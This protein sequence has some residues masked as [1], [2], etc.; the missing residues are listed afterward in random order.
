MLA[1]LCSLVVLDLSDCNLFEIPNHLISLSSLESLNLSGTMIETIPASLKQVSGMYDLNLSNCKRLQSLPE[2][3]FLIYNF[4]A[5]GCASLESVSRTAFTD[6]L[7]KYQ[8]R[9]RYEEFA[10]S[11]C[12]NLDQNGWSN[13]VTD[14]RLRIVRSATASLLL[15]DD[16]YESRR[17][18][19]VTIL[20]QG[21]EIPKWFNYQNEG[22]SIHIKLP[23]NWC[24]INF[25]GFAVCINFL[26]FAV[27]M[28]VSFNNCTGEWDLHFRCESQ[29]KSDSG[30]SYES[31]CCL[32]GWGRGK[33]RTRVINSDHVLMWYDLRLYINAVKEKE[34]KKF[35]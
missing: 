34:G 12:L 3:P 24:D 14:A 23:P 17:T 2:L 29:F 31:N 30:E 7:D 5:H 19:S 22:S 4:D 13:V 6:R 9:N 20:W 33:S 21:N 25:L 27:C 18:P 32:Y 10:L 28:V 26:G 11:N 1:G 35:V 15:K 16:N 8:I